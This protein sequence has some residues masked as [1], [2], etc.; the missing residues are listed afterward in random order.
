MSSRLYD[1]GFYEDRR[2]QVTRSA[3]RL[4]PHLLTVLPVGSVVDVGCG[5]GAWLA[6]L[7]RLGVED[8]FGVDGAW[9]DASRLLI[10]GE[11]F[12]HR[13]LA[14]SIG[15]DR[16]F[17]LAISLEVAEHL[18]P[19]RADGFVA[20]LVGLASVICF[21]AAVPGQGGTGHVN[22]QWPVYWAERFAGH[23]YRAVDF[24]RPLIWEDEQISYVYRQNLVV[25]ASQEGLSKYP[26]L[27]RLAG[28]CSPRPMALV[29]PEMYRPL[30]KRASPKLAKWIKMGPDAFRRTFRG[31]SV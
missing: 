19:S 1:A 2:A 24:L 5:D 31:R 11:C 28:R 16:R 7:G 26:E 6:E 17:D 14:R 3:V 20:E 25:Y 27:E 18:A 23:G 13:D 10:P 4:L 9:V 8:R 22:E 15:V 12:A 21:S 30:A 29:H